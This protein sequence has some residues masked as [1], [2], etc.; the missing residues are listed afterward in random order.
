[1]SIGAARTSITIPFDEPRDLHRLSDPDVGD[2]LLVVT[3]LGPA[4]GVLKS[5]DF[6]DFR[7]LPRPATA[8]PSSRSPTISRR[9]LS[10]DK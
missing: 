7:A 6:V 1:M 5:Q 4:R 8:S 3:A 10:A 2:T 9:S